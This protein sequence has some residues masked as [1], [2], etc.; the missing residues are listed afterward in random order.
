MLIGPNGSGKTTLL[1]LAMGLLTPTAGSIR[2]AQPTARRAA[3]PS[4]SRSR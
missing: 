4:C 3:S 2:Y 1:K